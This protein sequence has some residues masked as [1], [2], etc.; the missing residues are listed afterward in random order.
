MF[1]VE[2]LKQICC[3]TFSMKCNLDNTF[4]FS[5]VFYFLF[6]FFGDYYYLHTRVDKIAVTTKRSFLD[7][8]FC[9]VI[10]VT[11]SMIVYFELK[12]IIHWR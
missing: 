7:A 12:L 4:L 10:I 1:Q 2:L 11:F 9:A 6:L 3:R 5:I 8:K